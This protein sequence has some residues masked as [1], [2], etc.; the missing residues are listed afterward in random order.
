MV[1]VKKHNY[2]RYKKDRCRCDECCAAF[3]EYQKSRRKHPEKS[4]KIPAGPLVEFIKQHDGRLQG[5]Q[6]RSA[7]RW[8]VD[9]VDIFTADRVCV[10]R[11]FHP[12]EV[13]GDAW[14]EFRGPDELG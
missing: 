6:A 11:G 3:E 5:M 13:Y 8:L 4:F 1:A 2:T 7:K 9:G 12:F 14:F 10:T